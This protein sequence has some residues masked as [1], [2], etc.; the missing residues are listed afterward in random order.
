MQE[1]MYRRI[2]WFQQS[3]SML[4]T[5]RRKTEIN[6]QRNLIVPTVLHLVGMLEIVE[7]NAGTYRRTL[8]STVS[9][10]STMRRKAGINMQRNL[11][12]QAALHCF[13]HSQ[14]TWNGE[15]LSRN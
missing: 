2:L 4:A 9:M 7:E 10:L 3:V 6:V 5:V 1:L 14:H 8:W 15:K 11:M 13:H 12:V